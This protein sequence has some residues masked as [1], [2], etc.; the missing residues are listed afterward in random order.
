MFPTKVLANIILIEKE[1]TNIISNYTALFIESV[2]QFPSQH[3]FLNKHHEESC[4]IMNVT[5]SLRVSC[6]YCLIYYVILRFNRN[7]LFINTLLFYCNRYLTK[8][9]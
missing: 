4:E 6:L 5:S 8:I 1:H 3:F 9:S 7:K 2:I